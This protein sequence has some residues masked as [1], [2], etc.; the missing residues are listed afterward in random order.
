LSAGALLSLAYFAWLLNE[1]RGLFEFGYA[2]FGPEPLPYSPMRGFTYEQLWGH[3]A[4]TLLLGPG[5]LL[6]SVG[7]SRLGCPTPKLDRRRAFVGASVLCV[8]GTAACMFLSLRGRAIVDDELVYRMQATFLRE[9]HLAA[10]LGDITPPDVFTIATRLGYTGKYLPGEPIVQLLGLSLGVPALLHLPLLA[11]T[12]FAWRKALQLRLGTE[13]ADHATIALALSPTVIFTS[14][15]GLSEAT[16]LC[17]VALA[18]LGYEWARARRGIQGALLAALGIGFGMATRPQTMLPA[19][20][21]FGL[22]VFVAL[23]RRREWLAIAMFALAL[24]ASALG[25]GAY[26]TALGGS[27]LKLPWFL[28][29]GQEHFGFGRVWATERFEHTPW[30][31]LENLGVVLVRFNAW[32]LGF[33][34]SL[35]VLVLWFALP[36]RY[37]GWNVWYGVGLAIVAFEF[38]YYSPGMSDTGSLYHYELVLP[39]SLIAA[40]AFEYA[41]ARWPAF[42][43]A[44]VTLHLTLGTLGFDL[45]QAARMNRL[46]AAIHADSDHALSQ[47]TPPAILFHEL[48]ASESRPTGWVFDSFPERNRGKSDAVVTFPNLPAPLRAQVLAAYPWRSCWYYRRDP[49]TERPELRHCEDA[50]ELMDR[51][52]GADEERPLWLRPTAYLK[53]DF[54]PFEAAR[55][56]HLRDALGERIPLCCALAQGKRLGVP[57]RESLFSRCI[58]DHR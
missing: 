16:S 37:R 53:T 35:A 14:A 29:C 9:G 51:T 23:A 48:R 30:T 44:A 6:L 54:D 10:P 55:R 22:A 36:A 15:T 38:L 47:I 24:S 26:D 3:L 41:R 31:A 52:F 20:A 19:G 42:T 43:T 28:Q 8:V 39:G 34:C 27:P 50:R 7:W 2:P 56:G 40:R 17:C 12:L 46:V 18:A 5:L 1:P 13:T 21:V 32:W 49:N 11:L 58:V 57:L 4:R 45:E 33:P 25:V